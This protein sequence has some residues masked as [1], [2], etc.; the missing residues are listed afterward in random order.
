[1]NYELFTHDYIQ[2][3][4]NNSKIRLILNKFNRKFLLSYVSKINLL[5]LEIYY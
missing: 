2:K 1:M 3:I 5:F 4:F